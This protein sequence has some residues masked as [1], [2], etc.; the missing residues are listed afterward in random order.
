MTI[1]SPPRL[2]SRRARPQSDRER[3]Q[4]LADIY[5]KTLRSYLGDLAGDPQPLAVLPHHLD[6]MHE[7]ATATLPAAFLRGKQQAIGDLA[8]VTT[9]DQ[10]WLEHKLHRNHHFLH[11]SLGPAINDKIFLR[12]FHRS[13]SPGEKQRVLD[14]SLGSRIENLYGGIVWTATEAGYRSG[15]QELHRAVLALSHRLIVQQDEGLEG[16][17]DTIDPITGKK[18]KRKDWIII[19]AGWLGVDPDELEAEYLNLQVGVAYVTVGDNRVCP[20][21]DAAE[22]EYYAPA[23]SPL[24][25]EVCDGGPNCRCH[26]EII[27]SIQEQAA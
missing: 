21:C 7:V 1:V 27:T 20:G 26:L 16:F 4:A 10:L 23:V 17:E 12:Q 2:V 9:E 5:G 11:T 3:N 22:G 18:R 14:Q 19:L 13:G 6:R 15:A 8:A 25:G 24:P